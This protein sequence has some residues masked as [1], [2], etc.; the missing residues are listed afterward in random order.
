MGLIGPF[1]ITLGAMRPILSPL[2]ISLLL[3]S[4]Q[5]FAQKPGTAAEPSWIAKTV[6]DYN[7]AGSKL[8]NDTK[9][10]YLNL[11]HERQVDLGSRTTYRRSVLRIVTEAGV[12]NASKI[13]AEYDPA[14][15]RLVFHNIRIIR[16]GKTINKLELSKIKTIR[17]ETELDRSI[18]NGSVTAVLILEDVRKGDIIEYAYSLLGF[19]PV[20]KDKYSA[21]M[22][23]QYGAPVGQILYRIVCPSQRNLTIKPRL[24]TAAPVV[25]TEGNN[26]IYQWEFNHVAALHA[27]DDLPSWYDPFPSIQVSEFAS[28]NDICKWALPL[29]TC[30]HALSP[31]LKKQVEAIKAAAGDNQEK[32]VLATLRFVQDEVR[33]MGIEMGINSHRPHDP[34][35]IFGQRFGDC[36]DKS[37]LLCTMLRAMDIDASPVL[38]NTEEKQELRQMLPSPVAFDHCT[39]RVTLAGK[40]WWFDPTISFQ[41]GDLTAIAYPDYKCGLV[42]T[43]TTTGLTDIPLREPG[44]VIAKEN[45]TLSD[46]HGP[47]KLEVITTYTGS[48]ADG[49]RDEMNSNSLSDLQQNYLNFY[50]NYY[51]GAK[52]ADS[53]RIEDDDASGK[54]TTYETYT[55]DKIWEQERGLKK[56]S[57]EAVLINSILNKPR[58]RNRTMPVALTYPARYTEQIRIQLPEDWNFDHTPTEV[59]SPSFQ[60]ASTINGSG[61]TVN[62]T[63]IYETL[64]DHVP[65]EE[66]NAY[67]SNFNKMKDDLGY[68]LSDNSPLTSPGNNSPGIGLNSNLA[69]SLLCLSLLAGIVFYIRRR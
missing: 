26:K 68:E 41:R 66:T 34:D 13:S 50:S 63:Y 8:L 55:I 27:Q 67:F 69:K 48:F 61:R 23:V 9:D 18:Y 51:E 5:L 64:K 60:Y 58:E 1:F 28:W 42:L 30:G 47:A 20:F 57:F 11:V 33:Y 49:I 37:F 16:D 24:T 14:Y 12:Q 32:R 39:V 21:S 10:G 52:V 22:Q 29:F 53:L 40:S 43:D 15:Q 6:T 25:T 45:F 56:A 38:I 19:N 31:G 35:K 62:L 7:L 3:L 2:I 54:I 36:K 4:S 59:R 46:T 44:Q 17:Q 65:A